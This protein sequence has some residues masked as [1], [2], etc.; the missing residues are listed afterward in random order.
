MPRS[1]SIRAIAKPSFSI[2]RSMKAP[3]GATMTAVPV[4]FSGSGSTAVSSI[5]ETFATTPP[6][7]A[8]SGALPLQAAS[9]SN[10]EM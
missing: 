10:T 7:S 2:S 3:P 4:A 1:A 8:N 5:F 9:T 6:S